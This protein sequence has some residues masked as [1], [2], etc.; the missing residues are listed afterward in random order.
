[1]HLDIKIGTLAHQPFQVDA[2]L[3][4]GYICFLKHICFAEHM[5]VNSCIQV[6]SGDVFYDQKTSNQLQTDV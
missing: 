1:M 2:V 3:Y 4:E 5:T 6:I